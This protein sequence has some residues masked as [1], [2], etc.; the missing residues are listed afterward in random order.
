VPRRVIYMGSPQTCVR[1]ESPQSFLKL[2]GPTG[3]E[4]DRTDHPVSSE[5]PVEMQA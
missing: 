4:N 5:S 3:F 2:A 1:E